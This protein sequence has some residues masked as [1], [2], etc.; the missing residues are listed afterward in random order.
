[1]ELKQLTGQGADRS[2]IQRI[3]QDLQRGRWAVLARQRPAF[4]AFRRSLRPDCGD[5]DH[6]T[7]RALPENPKTRSNETYWQRHALNLI[8]FEIG[9]CRWPYKL[10]AGASNN[11]NGRGGQDLT[12]ICGSPSSTVPMIAALS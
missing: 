9:C 8:G 10:K 7:Q 2:A 3:G 12:I 11:K 4:Q 5:K 6:C 1:M